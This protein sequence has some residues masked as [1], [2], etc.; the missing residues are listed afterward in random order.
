MSFK[1]RKED[2]YPIV[3]IFK[4]VEGEG[5]RVG[6]PALFVRFGH[7]NLKC[8]WCDTLYAQDFKEM[9]YMSKEQIA[10][11][12]LRQHC[13]MVTFTGGEPLQQVEFIK[14]FCDKY[15]SFEVNIE[16]NGSMPLNKADYEDAIITM[17]WKCPSSGMN[18]KMLARNLNV[19][20]NSDVLK[21]VVADEKDLK[22]VLRVMME[23][24]PRATVFVNPVFGKMPFDVLARFIVDNDFLDMR[25]GLQ[26]H[27]IIWAPEM[28]GV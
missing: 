13:K 8:I 4:S 1:N 2:T 23:Y 19:L 28:R 10:A 17:D 25:M 11:E 6:A 9:N 15:P 26:I 14:W 21:F 20:D 12:I 24:H 7:C 22:E 5:I 27:K 16:T 3:E 18:D